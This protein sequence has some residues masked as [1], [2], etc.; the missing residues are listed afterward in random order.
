MLIL[1]IDEREDGFQTRK[2][3]NTKMCQ[4]QRLLVKQRQGVK[5]LG[6]KRTKRKDQRFL[7]RDLGSFARGNEMPRV[8][9]CKL[10]AHSLSHIL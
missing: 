4:I 3:L 5:D 9:A 7:T 8:V 2:G 6:E 1:I 10:P